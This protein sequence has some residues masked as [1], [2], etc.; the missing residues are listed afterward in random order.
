[1]FV[2][3]SFLDCWDE[4]LKATNKLKVKVRGPKFR[5]P[6]ALFNLAAFLSTLQ[7]F[8]QIEGMLAALAKLRQFKVPDYTTIFRRVRRL[9]F[10]INLD[11]LEDEFIVAIDSS[12]I[13]VSPRGEWLRRL[14]PGKKR[15]GLA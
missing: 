4:E 14:Y 3:F 9:R 8:R 12:G 2:D 6:N 1:M 13:K 10:D 7:G 15:R 11:K 5:Y